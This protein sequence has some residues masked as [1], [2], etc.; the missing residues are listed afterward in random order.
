MI[1][2]LNSLNFEITCSSIASNI[3]LKAL[4]IFIITSY[5][6]LEIC[7]CKKILFLIFSKL[8]CKNI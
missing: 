6:G 4:A 3:P 5:V 1:T 7:F 2:E 8:D